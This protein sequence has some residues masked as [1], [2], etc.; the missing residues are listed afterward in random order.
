MN[1]NKR[2]PKKKFLVPCSNMTKD[3]TL[4]SGGD[5]EPLCYVCRRRAARLADSNTKTY[6]AN[7]KLKK[8]EEEKKR[9]LSHKNK[10]RELLK[11]EMEILDRLA[12]PEFDPKKKEKKEKKNPCIIPT[13]LNKSN[14]PTLIDWASERLAEAL[15][16]ND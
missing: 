2:L 7:V 1:S 13:I 5:G 6:F 11:R 9:K 12:S 16:V 10:E 4:C 3:G 8:K 14:F 15:E